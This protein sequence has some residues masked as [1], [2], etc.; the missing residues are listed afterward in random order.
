MHRGSPSKVK[1][2]Q[3]MP[4]AVAPAVSCAAAIKRTHT[5]STQVQPNTS[6]IPRAMLDDLFRALLG[7][8][9]F[10]VTVARNQIANLTPASGC[11]D[12]TASSDASCALRPCALLASIASRLTF[13]DDWP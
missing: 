6:G 9:G 4:G 8:P 7:V 10:V 11:R 1:R 3:G 2:A 5:S 13:R 12:H